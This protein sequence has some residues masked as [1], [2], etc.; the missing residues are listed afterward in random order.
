M[1]R[2]E[3][4]FKI[5]EEECAEVA[6]RISKAMRF[7]PQEVQPGQS[8]N[9]AERIMQEYMDLQCMVIMLQREGHLPIWSDARR[10]LAI[11]AKEMQVEKYLKYSEEV[12]TLD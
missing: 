5:A 3:H 11:E 9:N 12:G 2:K 1:N 8:L 4:L 10:A 7:T 6:Q